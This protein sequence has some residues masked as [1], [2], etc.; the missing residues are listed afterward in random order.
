MPTERAKTVTVPKPW[1]VTDLRPWRDRTGE[2]APIGEVWYELPENFGPTPSLQLKLL[3]TSEP[4]SIQVHPDDAYARKAG[5][6]HGK[7]EAWYVLSAA[8]DAKVGVGLKERLAPLQLQHTITDGSI[9]SLTAWTRVSAGDVIFV[10]AGT[11]HAIG[12]GLVIAEIQQRGGATFRMFDHGRQRELHIDDAIAVADAGPAEFQVNP[13]KLSDERS[14]LI[15]SAFFVFERI[16][17]PPGSHWRLEA[18]QETWLLF[19]SGKTVAGPFDVAVGDAVFAN[20]DHI[21]IQAG[22]DGSTFL[23]AYAGPTT[24]PNFLSHLEDMPALT[25]YAPEND[26]PATRTTDKQR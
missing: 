21:D 2:S 26:T 4:L 16:D 8:C 19:L 6:Q 7:T 18:D 3:F 1:G 22:P 5:L 14:L 23:A 24:I 17:L 20:A 9:A 12:A 13:T 11:I 25:K 10:P 15:S